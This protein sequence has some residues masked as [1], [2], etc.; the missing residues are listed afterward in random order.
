MHS[1]QGGGNA[2]MF[3]TLLRFF[4]ERAELSQ[5]ALGLKI[6]F[7]KSQ[8]AMVER[9]QRPPKGDFV[10][11]AD[12]AL[13]AQGALV[14]TGEKLASSHL[15]SWFEQFA[16]EEAEAL[17]RHEFETYVVPGLLQT[18]KY[19]RTVFTSA[20]PPISDEEI[21][22]RVASRLK[23]QN[24]FTRENAPDISFVL[25]V[26][27]LTD[28]VGGRQTHR[29]QLRHIL[30]V[31]ELLHVQM[32]VLSPDRAT[33]PGFGGPFV[34]LETKEQRQL[35][36]LEAQAHNFLISEQPTV[37]NLF[38]KYGTLRAQ[39]LTPEDSRRL[40]EQMAKEL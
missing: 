14:A 10:A 13:S 31:A 35:V 16:E 26:S 11:R 25:K 29:A 15:A 9:G 7:S 18:E 8:V 38:G 27:A 22:G 17:A 4:R 33:Y 37:G 21:E 2:Q 6:G 20:Y 28:Q 12:E 5:E 3:G 24:L 19:A 32:Q 23:R 30:D 1:G 34:L 39:A 40:I 36:Y